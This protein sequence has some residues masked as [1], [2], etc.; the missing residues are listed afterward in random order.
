MTIEFVF[1]FHEMKEAQTQDLADKL[2]YSEYL[3]A[4][5]KIE[6]LT[7]EI[8]L[9]RFVGAA[10]IE[11]YRDEVYDVLI[12][13]VQKIEQ[14]K[15]LPACTELL[16]G[17][18]DSGAL[19]KIDYAQIN[20][21]LEVVILKVKLH[22]DKWR[23][24]SAEEPKPK[25]EAAGP[26]PLSPAAGENG[27]EALRP[28]SSAR[29]RPGMFTIRKLARL[30]QELKWKTERLEKI[31]EQEHA[32]EDQAGKAL[33]EFF[34][35]V[36][37]EMLRKLLQ[38]IEAQESVPLFLGDWDTAVDPNLQI[39]LVALF[40][41]FVE[42]YVTFS[43]I[44][45]KP[46]LEQ[47]WI[48]ELV[49]RYYRELVEILTN[50]LIEEIEVELI[51]CLNLVLSIS[52]LLKGAALHDCFSLFSQEG[53]TVFSDKNI[54]QIQ[55]SALKSLGLLYVRERNELVLD[56]V[57][58][59]FSSDCLSFF[60]LAQRKSI[61]ECAMEVLAKSLEP[62]RLYHLIRKIMYTHESAAQYSESAAQMLSIMLSKIKTKERN[63]T[64][65][66][67]GFFTRL[68]AR[69]PNKIEHINFYCQF[70]AV[71]NVDIPLH[72][73]IRG[74]D[75][76][77]IATFYTTYFRHPFTQEKGAKVVGDFINFVY[78]SDN[79]TYIYIMN[80]VPFVPTSPFVL[81]KLFLIYKRV[82]ANAEAFSRGVDT[83][84]LLLRMKTPA[85]VGVAG[86]IFSDPKPLLK[87]RVL[88]TLARTIN[89]SSSLSEDYI[90]FLVLVYSVERAKL[91]NYNYKGILAYL[92]DEVT[93]KYLGQHITE[94]LKMVHEAVEIESKDFYKTYACDLLKIATEPTIYP[95]SLR[96]IA[97][98]LQILFKKDKT[99]SFSEE[100]HVRFRECLDTLRTREL[101]LYNLSETFRR[102]IDLYNV[103]L[104]E[105]REEV[106][107]VYN[108]VVLNIVDLGLFY[109]LPVIRDGRDIKELLTR[110]NLIMRVIREFPTAPTQGMEIW[111][112]IYSMCVRKSAGVGKSLTAV[113]QTGESQKFSLTE[114]EYNNL[115]CLINIR[116]INDLIIIRG[117]TP[118]IIE[119]THNY[120][121]WILNEEYSLETLLALLRV[122]SREGRKELLRLAVTKGYNISEELSLYS[123]LHR[124]AK[125]S[126]YEYP[127]AHTHNFLCALAGSGKY[128]GI[129]ELK[130]AELYE[131]DLEELVFLS[132]EYQVKKAAE[133]L[134]KKQVVRCCTFF[135][136]IDR[137]S[138]I[139]ALSVIGNSDDE[140][141]MHKSVQR[142][143]REEA[144]GKGLMPYVP[145]IVQLLAKPFRKGG[146]D[147]KLALIRAMKPKTAHSLIWE[148]RAQGNPELAAYEKMILET[149]SG[150]SRR[151]YEKVATFLD[152]FASVS[153]RLK[154]YVG[155]DRDRKKQLINE[156][157]AKVTFPEGC[158]LPITGETV[159]GVVQGSGRALQSA[160][161]VPYMVTFKVEKAGTKEIV[162]RAVIFKFGD[163]CRQDVLAL[164][165]IK[166]FQSIFEEKGLSIFL[167]PYKVLATGEGS[168][169]IEVIP[170]AVSRDQI[171]RERVN[172]L[173][174]YFSL[175]YGYREGHKYMQALK[176]FVESFA[177]YSL[178]TY[179]LNIKDRH[180]G[181]IM[182]T[183]EGH[184]IHIDFGFM[185]DISPGNINIESPIKI[186]DEIFSLLGGSEGQAFAIYKD[187]MIKGFYMLRKRAKDIVLMID[188]GRHS[189][190]PCYTYATV[191]N[192]LARFRL[193]LKD[194]E[195]PAF[196]E[197]LIV[198]STKKLRTWIYDQ[199]QHLT[200]NIA[201]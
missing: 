176:N 97:H 101:S 153:G 128:L 168:G 116:W 44:F 33:E 84:L 100:L 72:H 192:L 55:H 86:F 171:G 197:K 67:N 111:E 61:I 102:Y 150:E 145:Q 182:L 110:S 143:E 77:F 170:K 13:Y 122:S 166:L 98:V 201:F 115:L 158:Y 96:I 183:D 58:S 147:V 124:A 74:Y 190:L 65:E 188:L 76:Q 81:L 185:F 200:N 131:L 177:G 69:S 162:D 51:V 196:V 31:A 17:I 11:E 56:I 152:N 49:G 3:E 109:A 194:E 68:I 161:K 50:M 80:M 88:K 38:V 22:E 79:L 12:K 43:I 121:Q 24:K 127:I 120:L 78:M 94:V 32:Q 71:H 8:A 159:V 64:L 85:L 189:G 41:T 60:T 136:N 42:E 195:V 184:L 63:V 172:N 118:G 15:G 92:K 117:E 179:I 90:V 21:I 144:K 95:L 54:L 134:L 46:V 20:S 108:Y 130:L 73:L 103:I 178:V 29:L 75:P 5:R 39:D 19:R 148:I 26:A 186:T 187:L 105:L 4:D 27:G 112:W 106:S 169:I 10:K 123:E 30:R 7:A 175:K 87:R 142:L 83:E 1:I 155:L 137:L 165:I 139:D 198:S 114:E 23:A 9:E 160:E 126:Y 129:R 2:S 163:D 34:G 133:I 181:N 82:Y 89:V 191:R 151:L 25:S 173:V 104:K 99:I 157:I 167:Y 119:N 125:G 199:Y 91:E 6:E 59:F 52:I 36:T 53:K 138:V 18:G 164:Q 35:A 140:H 146:K 66:L 135:V 113:M 14:G 180:N 40:F 193:D 132:T 62:K 45:K 47:E 149:M 70:L 107:E 156:E 93:L 48:R 57:Y 174:D 154:K 28:P 141:E 37:P 16:K